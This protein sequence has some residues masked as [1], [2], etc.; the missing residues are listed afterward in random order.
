MVK[1]EVV[2]AAATALAVTTVAVKAVAGV[3]EP[4]E[5][6]RIALMASIVACAF[7]RYNRYVI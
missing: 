2:Q 7:G 3:D 6:T 4:R 5:K 1:V